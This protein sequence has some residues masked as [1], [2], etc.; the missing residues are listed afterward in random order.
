MD[1]SNEEQTIW[2]TAYSSCLHDAR[3]ERDALREE[4]N[5]VINQLTDTQIL[6]DIYKDLYA[7]ATLDTALKRAGKDK[8]ND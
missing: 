5:I 7:A 2:L 3:A 6:V 4:L 8:S 1:M